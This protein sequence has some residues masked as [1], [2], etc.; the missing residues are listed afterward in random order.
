MTNYNV[1]IVVLLV[2]QIVETQVQHSRGARQQSRTLFSG[3]NFQLSGQE[4]SG[5]RH[6]KC[7]WSESWPSVALVASREDHRDNLLYAHYQ[8]Y[9]EEGREMKTFKAPRILSN[10]GAIFHQLRQVLSV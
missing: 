6:V 9:R 8:V 2:C 10:I 3:H 7:Q 4:R 1:K 5:F